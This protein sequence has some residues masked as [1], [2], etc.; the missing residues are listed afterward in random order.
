MKFIADANIGLRIL[1]GNKD[2]A[3]AADEDEDKRI[4]M[5]RIVA[6]TRAIV[7]QVAEGKIT[8]YFQDS[9]VEE[10]VFVMQK[11]YNVPRTN[12]SK[13]ILALIEAEGVEASQTIRE[14][15]RLYGTI[16]LDLIDIKLYV[17]SREL[18][19]PLLSWDKGFKKFKDLEYYM[20]GDIFGDE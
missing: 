3:V 16:N 11:V 6:Q 7:Q 13:M 1:V 18:G 17:V 15:V 19:I 4:A 14:T 10:M 9:I 8:L 5:E 12:I 20:P 2:I